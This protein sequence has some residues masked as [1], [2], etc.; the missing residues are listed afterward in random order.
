[1]ANQKYW[2]TLYIY[3]QV[4]L[5]IDNNKFMVEIHLIRS[6][7]SFDQ[8]IAFMAGNVQKRTLI[9]SGERHTLMAVQFETILNTKKFTDSISKFD[10]A[11][12]YT[13]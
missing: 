4:E 13:F 1:M 7:Y 6:V 10:W 3:H 9:G 12:A 5:L 2:P 8:G 11:C